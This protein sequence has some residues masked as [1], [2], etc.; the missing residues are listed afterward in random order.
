MTLP[1]I[2]LVIRVDYRQWASNEDS[3][4]P[5]TVLGYASSEKEANDAVAHF[6]AEEPGRGPRNTPRFYATEVL[7]I[8]GTPHPG[9]P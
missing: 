9:T 1:S 4:M 3:V 2:W 7:P 5:E 6:Q 8:A